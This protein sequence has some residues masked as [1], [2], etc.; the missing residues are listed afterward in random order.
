MVVFVAA[1]IADVSE[2]RASV[3]ILFVSVVLTPA[4]VLVF[5]VDI[6]GPPR[7]SV[8]P[9]ICSFAKS[10]S[11]SEV[12][13]KESVDNST[14]VRTNCGFCNNLSNVDLC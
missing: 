4:C 8:L 9:K 11:S 6:P 2:P 10:S 3:D 5:E 7:F 12:A 14:R 1:Y 13:H